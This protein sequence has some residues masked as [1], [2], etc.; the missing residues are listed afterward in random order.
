M[1]KGLSQGYVF[2]VNILLKEHPGALGE[3]FGILGGEIMACASLRY[4]I[5]HLWMALHILHQTA[6]HILALRHN[7]YAARDMLQYGVQQQ[8]VMGARQDNGV[9]L[10]IAAQQFVNALV[11]EVVGTRTVCLISLNYGS[12]QRTCLPR[13]HHIGCLMGNLQFV[14][15]AAYSALGGKNANVTRLCQRTYVFCCGTYN[16]KNASVAT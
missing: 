15:A 14:A 3:A 13:H 11:N 5:L 9:Y 2:H 8:R 6:C 10:R 12:P 1:Y 16:T 4:A 7:S